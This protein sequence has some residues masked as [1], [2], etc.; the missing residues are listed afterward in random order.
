VLGTIAGGL[1]LG[2]GGATLVLISRRRR[3]KD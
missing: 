2:T 3:E 1:L